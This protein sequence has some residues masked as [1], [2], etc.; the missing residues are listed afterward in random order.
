MTQEP[1]YHEGHPKGVEQ[2]PQR[3]NT[4]APSP[5]NKKKKKT[6]IATCQRDT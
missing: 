1:L 4:D 5:S 2:D 6:D 3:I